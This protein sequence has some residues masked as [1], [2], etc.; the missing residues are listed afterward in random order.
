MKGQIFRI[1]HLGNFDFSDVFS[2]IAGL[3]IILEANGH[4]VQVRLGCGCCAA[5]LYGCGSGEGGC[6]RLR[7]V[8]GSVGGSQSWLQPA[9]AGLRQPKPPHQAD[10]L[11]HN[12]RGI[13]TQNRPGINEKPRMQSLSKGEGAGFGAYV[14]D[15]P[16]CVATGKTKQQVQRRIKKR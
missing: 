14:P 16:G 10:C 15:L 7:F 13:L 2:L 3:E 9:P 12:W 5:S 8:A 1:A 11:P 4:P 6:A